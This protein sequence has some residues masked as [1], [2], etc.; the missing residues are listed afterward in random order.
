IMAGQ[1]ERRAL[2]RVRLPGE[3]A[4]AGDGIAVDVPGGEVTVVDPAGLADA[5][6]GAA[7]RRME[8]GYVPEIRIVGVV[9]PAP[10]GVEVPAGVD[11]RPGHGHREGVAV[12]IALPV[13]G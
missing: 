11:P 3:A 12:E 9:R 13:L 7:A 4:R 10:H 8:A 1:N 2:G 6:S 5:D